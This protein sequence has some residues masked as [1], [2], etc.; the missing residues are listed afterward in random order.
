MTGRNHKSIKIVTIASFAGGH[1]FFF[2]RAAQKDEVELLE[3]NGSVTGEQAKK[4]RE[5]GVIVRSRRPLKSST[6]KISEGI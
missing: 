6:K 5:G 2:L 1:D 4:Y 3:V